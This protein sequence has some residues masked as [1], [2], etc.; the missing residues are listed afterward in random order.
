VVAR[1]DRVITFSAD[2]ADQV[3]HGGALGAHL[4]VVLICSN[5]ELVE[6][7]QNF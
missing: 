1:F 3:L 7:L 5:T 2:T 6:P 4:G